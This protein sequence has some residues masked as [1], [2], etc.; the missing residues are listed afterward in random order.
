[1][2]F[3]FCLLYI[4]NKTK[5]LKSYFKNEQKD[6][7]IYICIYSTY[8]HFLFASS[9][10][11]IPESFCSSPGT[12]ICCVYNYSLGLTSNEIGDFSCGV[13]SSPHHSDKPFNFSW[14]QTRRSLIGYSGITYYLN[15]RWTARDETTAL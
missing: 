3:P 12:F 2:R 10:T 9:N 8:I 5:I 6:I 14:D 13:K 11:K 15:N 4:K 1:M 7:Y